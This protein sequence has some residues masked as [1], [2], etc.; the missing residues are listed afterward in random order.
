MA[1]AAVG[2]AF[3][4]GEK[5]VF[6]TLRVVKRLRL[7]GLTRGDQETLRETFARW[8]REKPHLS[9]AL[10]PL[11]ASFEKANY[12]SAS[13]SEEEWQAAR[14]LARDLLKRTSGRA[15]ADCPCSLKPAKR[16]LN[17]RSPAPRARGAFSF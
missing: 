4:P 16:H 14:R 1:A 9:G 8:K 3:T 6:E 17:L 12:S 2:P 7:R 15:A 10:D 5:T 11:L 13:V